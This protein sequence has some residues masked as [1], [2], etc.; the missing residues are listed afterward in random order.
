MKTIRYQL[1][2]PKGLQLRVFPKIGIKKFRHSIF[3]R[4]QKEEQI[5]IKLSIT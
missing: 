4:L 5:D 1:K 2:Y 3:M